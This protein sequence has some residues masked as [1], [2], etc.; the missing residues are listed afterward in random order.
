[1][2]L[3]RQVDRVLFS[4]RRVS[5]EFFSVTCLPNPG[6]VSSRGAP[7][8][9]AIRVPRAVGDAVVRNRVK[10]LIREVFRLGKENFKGE[11]DI[12]VQAK[13]FKEAGGLDYFSTHEKLSALFKK[14]G[15]WR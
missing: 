4:G 10:R 1:M 8:R 15:L 7:V 2:R 9:I 11:A 3:D 12:V 5:N 6:D 14:A 13:P